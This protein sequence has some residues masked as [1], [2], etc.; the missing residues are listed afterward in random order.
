MKRKIIRTNKKIKDKK[1]KKSKEEIG[2]GKN[3]TVIP[4]R[5][6]VSNLLA[7]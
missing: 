2:K 6:T 4:F 7:Q 5:D 1:S 3:K